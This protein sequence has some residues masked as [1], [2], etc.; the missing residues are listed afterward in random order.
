M[1]LTIDLTV[2]EQVRLER[3]AF[4]RGLDV[5]SFV[6]EMIAALPT[7]AVSKGPEYLTPEARAQAFLAW[8]ESHTHDSPLLTDVA[9][10]RESIYGED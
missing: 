1:T 8:A 10:S 6:R 3:K 7:D 4:V 2:E 5:N 9:V